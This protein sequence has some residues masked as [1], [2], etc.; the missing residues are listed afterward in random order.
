MLAHLAISGAIVPGLRLRERRKL[1]DDDAL[2]L[3]PFDH[4][5]PPVSGQHRDRMTRQGR[6]D[7]LRIGLKLRC[8]VRGFTG[9]D[10]IG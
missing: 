1:Q 4:L 2:H 3:R 6:A 7:L 9:K 8:I 5:L 10:N